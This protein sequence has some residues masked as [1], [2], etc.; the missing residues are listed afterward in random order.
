MMNLDGTET[1]SG[2]PLEVYPKS[3]SLT[4]NLPSDHLQALDEMLIKLYKHEITDWT[5]RMFLEGMIS[6]LK[7]HF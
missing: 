4:D 3:T 6:N 2:K 5:F 7:L 1:C